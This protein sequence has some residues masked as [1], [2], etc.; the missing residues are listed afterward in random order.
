MVSTG[1]TCG[2]APPLSIFF[3]SKAPPPKISIASGFLQPPPSPHPILRVE[4]LGPD[5]W[6][7][8]SRSRI[9]VPGSPDAQCLF[10][11]FLSAGNSVRLYCWMRDRVRSASSS[12][13]SGSSAGSSKGCVFLQ[14]GFRRLAFLAGGLRVIGGF[15]WGFGVLRS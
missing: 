3:P 11:F 8:P 1:T 6:N 12:S 7:H 2:N 10:F 13:R 5:L 14:V 15:T 9:K 4:F